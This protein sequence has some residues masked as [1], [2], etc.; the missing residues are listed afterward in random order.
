MTLSATMGQASVS[1]AKG[2][3]GASASGAFQI[4]LIVGGEASGADTVTIQNFQLVDRSQT[5]LIDPLPIMTTSQTPITVDKGSSQSV[6][7]T[8][9]DATVDQTAACAGPVAIIGSVSDT[10]G[11]GSDT[12]RSGDITPS[13]D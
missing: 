12:V 10:L 7:F 4:H 1:V 3:F 11:D 5:A 9:K 2:A 6:D 13:C 8:F